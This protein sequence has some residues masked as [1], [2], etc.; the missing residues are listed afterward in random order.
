MAG[1]S[2]DPDGYSRQMAKL[3]IAAALLLSAMTVTGCGEQGAGGSGTNCPGA[4]GDRVNARVLGAMGTEEQ[5]AF[6]EKLDHNV[7]SRF[8]S[9][10]TGLEFDPTVDDRL[11]V[12]FRAGSVTPDQEH[13]IVC[14]V[15][16]EFGIDPAI[17]VAG[18]QII[19]TNL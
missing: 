2:G 13:G 14:D 6:M 5:R 12:L 11:A 3:G 1:D 8:L 9:Q 17:L 15:A 19:V 7:R 10:V 4:V 16:T 18:D